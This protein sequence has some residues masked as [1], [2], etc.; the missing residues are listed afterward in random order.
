MTRSPVALLLLPGI[1]WASIGCGESGPPR[2]ETFPVAGKVL[3][4]GKP[5]GFLAVNCVRVSEIDKQ[6]RTDSQCLTENDGSFK[7]ATYVASDGVPEGDYVLTFQWGEIN[8]FTGAYVGDKLNGR[9][10]DP[11][12]S[13]IK[14]TVVKGKPTNL[15]EIK[16]TT[17]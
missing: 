1:A 10:S 11:A 8:G 5:P 16:L 12:M 15:G 9:Y 3:V 14:F 7:I 2:N 13:T 6:N 4:D 17:Q